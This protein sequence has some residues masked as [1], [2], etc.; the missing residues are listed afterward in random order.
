[1]TGARRFS[2]SACVARHMD[3][4][5]ATLDATTQLYTRDLRSCLCSHQMVLYNYDSQTSPCAIMY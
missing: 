1:M 5:L 3:V 4:F 2:W